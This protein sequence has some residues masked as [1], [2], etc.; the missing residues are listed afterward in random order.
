MAIFHGSITHT[1]SGRK[2][3]QQRGRKNIYK[4]AFRVLKA[5]EPYRRET[6]EY[7]SAEIVS[8][9]TEKV[10]DNFRKDISA[11]YTIAPAYNKGAYQVISREN[12]KDI[13]R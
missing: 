2:K 9:V 1:Y 6:P 8:A 13:G 7:K 11:K 12:V 4:P 10:E 3:K 5:T